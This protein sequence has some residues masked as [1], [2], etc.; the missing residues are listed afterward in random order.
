MTSRI[1]EGIDC[2]VART[3]EQIGE[4]WTF[5]ILR[6]AF[7][8]IRRFGD[9]QDS[10]GIAKNI[11]TTRL[12]KL[13]DAGIMY[14]SLYQEHPPRY[15]YRLTE[16]GRDLVPILTTLL[17]WGDKWATDGDDPVKLIHTECGAVMHTKTVCGHCGD[18]ITAFN[19]GIDPVPPIV[20]QRVIEAR[21]RSEART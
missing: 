21:D 7:Y 2:S 20:T 8:G 14:K 6:D 10:L 19:L 13:V 4:R 3:V 18:P 11:L 17:A 1:Y 12:T 15:E 16:K 9:F 5:L